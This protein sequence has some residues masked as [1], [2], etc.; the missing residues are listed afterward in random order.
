MA[1]KDALRKLKL[2]FVVVDLG[3]VDIMENINEEQRT[4]LKQKGDAD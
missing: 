1:V 2:H 4:Q 3:E